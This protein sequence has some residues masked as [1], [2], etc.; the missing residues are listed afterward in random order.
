MDKLKELEEIDNLCKPIVE[1]LHRDF[2]PHTAIIITDECIKVVSDE[3]SIPII[4]K[5][6]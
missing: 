3:I 5:E 2:N 4:Y 6:D 1:Y